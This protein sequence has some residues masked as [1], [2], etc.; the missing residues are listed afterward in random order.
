MII[1]MMSGCAK[2]E[3]KTASG[4]SADS[5]SIQDGQDSLVTSETGDVSETGTSATNAAGTTTTAG[6]LGNIVGDGSGTSKTIPVVVNKNNVSVRVGNLTVNSVGEPY[7]K[8]GKLPITIMMPYPNKSANMS[9][10]AFTSYY[11][12]KSGI[13][14]SYR[15]YVGSDI[16]VLKASMMASG[17]LPDIFISVHVGF[18]SN[19][20]KKYGDEG[21]FANLTPYMATWAPNAYARLKANSYATKVSY[22][23]NGKLYCLP[24]LWPT[25]G[26]ANG[27]VSALSERQFMINKSWLNELGLKA[28]GTVN[29]FYTV[30]KAFTEDDPDGN[31]KDDTYGFGIDLWTPQLWNP[32]GLNMSRY[33]QGTIDQTGKVFCGPL[34]DEFREGCRF[35]NRMWKEGIFDKNM[36]GA[37]GSALKT[38]VHKTGIVAMSYVGSCLSDNEMSNWEAIAC[39]KASNCGS[40]VPGVAET[41]GGQAGCYENMFF[42]SA[43]TKSVQACLRW[44]DYFYTLDGAM[45]WNYGPVG[46]AYTKIGNKYKLMKNTST[47]AA[48]QN[49]LCSYSPL[50]TGNILA[51][52]SSELTVPEQYSV[53]INKEAAVGNRYAKYF[54]SSLTQLE[55]ES[56]KKTINNLSPVGDVQWGYKAIR[57]E[58]NV[59]TDWNSY[60]SQ[61]SKDFKTWDSIYQ[62]I[63]NK[64][65][66]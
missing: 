27:D 59:E 63:F 18:E 16:F 11:E 41:G 61:Y 50:N 49:I 30:A 53:R 6:K 22:T 13:K 29:D 32:W 46:K 8:G 1:G 7:V 20:V 47:L 25:S 56:Q 15:F 62:G 17:N 48:K 37:Q 2:K 36:V 43:K 33:Y 40:F 42:V 38:E 21:Y 45:L 44:L 60:Y 57:G 65:F 24:T 55:S 14:A 19:E 26:E 51:R 66:K 52:N 9:G 64:Y 31:G 54:F 28:P 4:A 34:T 35:Y 5:S 12:A 23:D 58:V 39:P 3:P 10:Q